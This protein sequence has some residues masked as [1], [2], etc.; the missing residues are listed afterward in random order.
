[1]CIHKLIS[2]MQVRFCWRPR[3]SNDCPLERPLAHLAQTVAARPP[4]IP[5]ALYPPALYLPALFAAGPVAGT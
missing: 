4:F 2:L 5:P 1:M 3:D